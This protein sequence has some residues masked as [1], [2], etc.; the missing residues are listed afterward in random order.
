[1]CPAKNAYPRKNILEYCWAEGEC[2]SDTVA[3]HC[4]AHCPSVTG[5]EVT[6]L[7]QSRMEHD[8]CSSI[9]GLDR[10]SRVHHEARVPSTS[11]DET[12]ICHSDLLPVKSSLSC[13]PST[14]QVLLATSIAQPGLGVNHALPHIDH[15]SSQ[16]CTMPS[17]SDVN[18]GSSSV[19]VD[20]L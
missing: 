11:S 13:A 20:A 10:P 4:A 6:L 2:I 18:I 3:D 16:K 14:L 8:L 7:S 5:S 17:W 9:I 1:M 12:A 15:H 19:L